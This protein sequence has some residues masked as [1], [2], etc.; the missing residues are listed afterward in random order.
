[1]IIT[2]YNVLGIKVTCYPS[3]DNWSQANNTNTTFSDSSETS[4]EYSGFSPLSD[5]TF[6]TVFYFILFCFVLFGLILILFV[7]SDIQY[8]VLWTFIDY[9]QLPECLRIIAHL[10]RIGVFSESEMRLQVKLNSCS[11]SYFC[12]KHNFLISVLV[13]TEVLHAHARHAQASMQAN[14]FRRLVF[15]H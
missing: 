2:I 6:Y 13:F 5:N 14:A 11:F 1:M 12:F 4:V 10:R 7:F 3:I 9:M 8:V 15:S